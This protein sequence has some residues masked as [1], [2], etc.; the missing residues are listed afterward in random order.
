M[1]NQFVTL[2]F[3]G[4][5][6]SGKSTLAQWLGEKCALP[7]VDGDYLGH[8]AL[9]QPDV[10]SQLVKHFGSGILDPEGEIDRSKLGSHVWGDDPQS[11]Q[12]RKELER[13]VHPVIRQAMQEAIEE[14]RQAGKRGVIID[15][16]VIIEAGWHG[17]CD[18]MIFVE[19][20]EEKRLSHVVKSR[21]WTEQEFRNRERS[22]LD[23]DTKRTHAHFVVDNS[24]S[25]EQSGQQLMQWLHQQLDR[26]PGDHPI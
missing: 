22:Q 20:P 2:C 1:S 25:I 26:F 19:T 18:R 7:V 16:A 15:A 23:L 14:A 11:V 8:L 6:G 10:I 12:N 21:N 9:K 3:V 13:I 4:G 5:V 24:G 17:I